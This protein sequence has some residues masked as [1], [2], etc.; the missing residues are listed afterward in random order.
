MVTSTLKS[1][2]LAFYFL[3]ALYDL[4]SHPKK[5]FQYDCETG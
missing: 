3:Y 2:K 4:Y 1:A 5:S